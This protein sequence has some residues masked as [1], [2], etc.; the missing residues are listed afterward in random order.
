MTPD[1]PPLLATHDVFNQA[2]PRE[3]VN[4]YA[5][6]PALQEA[7]AREGAGWADAWLR[8]RG[9][10]LGSAE[11]IALGAAANRHPPALQLFDA[12]GHRRDAVEFHPSYHALMGYLKHHGASGRPWG[13]ARPGAHVARAAFYLLF[14]EIE[15]G[16]LCPTTMTYAVVPALRREPALATWVAKALSPDY[17]ERF[18]PGLQKRGVTMGMGMTEKQGGSDV[19]ANT[20]RAEP[21]GASAWGDE[22]RITGHK[23]F[24]S[25]PM[26]DA[27]LILAQAPGGLTCFFLPRFTPEGRPNEIRIQRLKDKLGDRSNAGS[28]VEFWGARAWRV[29]AEGRG[30]PTILEMGT[31]T[32]LDCA[33]GTAGLMRAAVSHAIHHA[34]HRSAFGKPL[35]DQPLMQNV[36]ADMA[37]E[38]EAATALALRLARAFDRS[39]AGDEQ[40]SLLARV[41]TPA[42]KYWICKRGPVLGGEAMEVWGGNGYV[43]DGPLARIYRQMPLNSIWEGSG[44]IMGLDVLRE[45][46]REPRCAEALAAELAPALGR[47]A[48]FDAF[49]GRLREQLA[50]PHAVEMQARTLTQGI[51]LAVQAALLLRHAPPAVAEA[52]CRS[53]LE[54]NHWGA[55]FGTLA[56]DTDFAAI[57][58]RAL[59][60]DAA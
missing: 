59:P 28:E 57:L 55:A 2:P 31:Y 6:N 40:E 13:E 50:A 1:H 11:M 51:A 48:A 21:V 7:V 17:D 56:P 5:A 23:W 10:E 18:I 14:A 29:G 54:P 27:F 16:T 15:D 12:T 32:R 3:N 9:A 20:T 41:L 47:H 60:E 35:A 43:E 34:R 36:L 53:R 49:V 39:L 45:L 8:E 37:L 25:A 19:R 26:C 42:A 44:N 24:F 52:F 33:L 38:S 30:V 22:Y 46:S 58:A 4:L